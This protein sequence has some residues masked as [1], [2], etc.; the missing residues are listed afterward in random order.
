[1]FPRQFFEENTMELMRPPLRLCLVRALQS[2]CPRCGEGR[3]YVRWNQLHTAC[4]SCGCALQRREQ[5]GW[6]FIYMTTAGLTG[7]IIVFMLLVDVPSVT[8]GQ[9]GVLAVWFVL[10]VLT[11]PLRKAVAISLDYYF[12]RRRAEA[13][14]IPPDQYLR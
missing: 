3:I 13:T 9:A 8:L 11:L 14:S 10:I 4:A 12:E 2:R 7:V 6:F 1:M 5:D